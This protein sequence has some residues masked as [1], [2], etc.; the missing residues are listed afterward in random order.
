MKLGTMKSYLS[1]GVAGLFLASCGNETSNTTGMAYNDRESGGFQVNLKYEGQQ[2][3]PGLV[4]IEG[5]NFVMGQVEEDFIKDWNNVPRRVTVSS[6]YMDENEVT[7]VD[8]REYLYWLD[9]V[10]KYDYPE[11]YEAAL[12]DTLVWRHE[13]AYNEVYV[14][15]YLRHPAYNFYPVVGVSWIQ[16]SRYCSWRT[17]RVN[18]QILIDNGTLNPSNDQTSTDHFSTEVYLYGSEPYTLQNNRGE[19]DLRPNSPYGEEG[20]PVRIEDGILLPKYRL[21]T[22]AEWEFAA[23]GNI[24]A[25]VY[26]RSTDQNKYTWNGSSL[27]NGSQDERGDMLANYKRG[28]GDNMGG[29]GWLNDQADITMQVRFYPPNDYG[30]YDMAGNVS[31]WVMDVYRPL[32]T[33]DVED[34]RAFRGNEFQTFD[35]E[36][37]GFLAKNY[38]P[39]YER[40]E[41]GDSVLVGLPGELPKRDV[42]VEENLDRRNYQYSD[43]RDYVDGDIQSSIYY[44]SDELEEG[45]AAMYDYAETTLIGNTTRVYKGGSW[46]DRAYWLSPGTRRFL[47]EDQAT[48]FLGFRCAMDRVGFQNLEEDREKRHEAP[49]RHD[50]RRYRM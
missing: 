24:G 2:T 50:F 21:P 48:D 36:D 37:D 25:R 43:Y 12:P 5:G 16:A 34:H 39:Q 3:G 42:T 13:M 4:F 49:D 30:L 17:D 1:L 47:E 33:M 31:E 45:Q 15:N 27:R 22:E 11:V 14:E 40:T 20:R 18:E 19:P 44:E 32:S 8:Y 9:R 28:D 6:F 7:N 26:D 38:E 35:E 41:D 23:Y 29:P 10:Y 46:K